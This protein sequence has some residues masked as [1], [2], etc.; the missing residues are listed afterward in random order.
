MSKL[1]F[2]TLRTFLIGTIALG[3]FLF[4]PAWTLYYWQ[5]IDR[6]V[7]RENSYGALTIQTVKD[8]KVISTGP[9]ALVR[10][11]MYVGVLVMM[12]GVPLALGSWWGNEPQ[13]GHHRD[14]TIR[15]Q[16]R[17]RQTTHG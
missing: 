4:L 9:Y 12:M 13:A 14:A 7:F 15:T 8:Q 5:A 11:P 6:F 1:F 16:D 3:G 2:L 10:H 17:E